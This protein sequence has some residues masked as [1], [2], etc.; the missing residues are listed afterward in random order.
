MLSTFLS[1]EDLSKGLSSFL[2]NFLKIPQSDA[3]KRKIELTITKEKP[4]LIW[5]QLLDC[6]GCSEKLLRT[7]EWPLFEYLCTLVDLQY[8]ELL[9]YETG[10]DAE[11]ILE[12]IT[13]G[14]K[15]TF[16]LLIEGA[17][18]YRDRG[19]FLKIHEEAILDFLI[20]ISEKAGLII[21]YGNCA[22]TGGIP[23]T[24][25][26]PT[27]AIGVP[28]L[29]GSERVISLFGCPGKAKALVALVAH[30]RLYGYLPPTD[31]TG[32]PM[33]G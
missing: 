27:C 32:R 7:K 8:H 26:S 25:P 16:Y 14:T 11:A 21:A 31:R 30:L 23:A 28:T 1:L 10:K 18:P 17:I 4:P 15:G 9:M 29:L 20:R 3:L 19:R 6:A 2:S 5:L 33:I 13:E 22:V 24:P 12:T